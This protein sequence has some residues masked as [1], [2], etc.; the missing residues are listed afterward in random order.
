VYAT[1]GLSET[2]RRTGVSKDAILV[3]ARARGV[4]PDAVTEKVSLQNARASAAAVQRTMRERQE[5]RERMVNRLVKVSEAALIRELELLAAGGFSTH[6]LQALSNT[7]MR[8][9]QQF[10]LLEGRATS[11]MDIGQEQLLQGVALAFRRALELVAEDV[12]EQVTAR[13]AAELRDVREEV[14][15]LALEPPPEDAEF[16]SVDEATT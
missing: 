2:S 11:R 4:D 15:R 6:D 12:R 1:V 7:R 16:T 13:F 10:E 9:I 14:Q 8:A 5:A 3:W